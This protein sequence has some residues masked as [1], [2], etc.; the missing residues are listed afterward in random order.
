MPCVHPYLPKALALLRAVRRAQQ[1]HLRAHPPP[2]QPIPLHPKPTQRLPLRRRQP[3]TPA[4]G[5]LCSWGRWHSGWWCRRTLSRCAPVPLHCGRQMG[6]YVN[7]PVRNLMCPCTCTPMR[8]C[9]HA[10][11]R[12]L[13]GSTHPPWQ[14]ACTSCSTHTSTHMLHPPMHAR[15]HAFMRLQLMDDLPVPGYRRE[16]WDQKQHRGGRGG[17]ANG[18]AGDKEPKQHSGEEATGVG[19]ASLWVASCCLA[20]QLG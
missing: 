10:A 20:G 7:T 6:Q 5:T 8:V 2:F 9:T 16:P 4:T 14:H 18:V 1:E 19:P 3:S 11:V 15:T 13:M 12:L 17:R